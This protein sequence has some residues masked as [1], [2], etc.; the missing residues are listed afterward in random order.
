MK[1][2]KHRA[3]AKLTNMLMTNAPIPIIWTAA[4]N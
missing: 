2:F 3:T 4:V 1:W